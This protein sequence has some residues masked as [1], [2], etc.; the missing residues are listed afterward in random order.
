MADEQDN[1]GIWI[2]PPLTYLLTLL[3]GL[4][5]DR[6]LHVPFLPHGVARVLG[7]PLVGGGIALATW[8]VRTMRGA[9]TTLD[10]GKPVSSL[11]QDEPFRYSRNPGYLSLA[12]IYAG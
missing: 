4:V 7:C 3:L 8:F 9:D 10:I 2:P 1:P 6:W 5:L 12:M 11:V